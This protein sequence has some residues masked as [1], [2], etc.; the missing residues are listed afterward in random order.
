MILCSFHISKIRN[1]F[2]MDRIIPRRTLRLLKIYQF[3]LQKFLYKKIRGRSKRNVLLSL[4]GL[5]SAALPV[6]QHHAG[7][8]KR[9][10]R[11]SYRRQL[12]PPAAGRSMPLSGWAGCIAAA[13]R[14]RR[15]AG[16][17]PYFAARRTGTYTAAPATP[18]P[19]SR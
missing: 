18:P 19:A 8:D 9:R 4:C 7:H 11:Q 12:L 5:F 2:R 16:S 6:F 3:R 14:C 13:T 15:A 17:G 1:I 10:S